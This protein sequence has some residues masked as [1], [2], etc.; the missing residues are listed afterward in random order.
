[1]M[2]SVMIILHIYQS[3]LQRNGMDLLK[4]FVFIPFLLNPTL[5]SYDRIFSLSTSIS[6]LIIVQ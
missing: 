3:Y 5:M 6:F 2:T 1:M 4:H